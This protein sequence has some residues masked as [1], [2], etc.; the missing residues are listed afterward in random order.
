MVNDLQPPYPSVT[1]VAVHRNRCFQQLRE[2]LARPMVTEC[3]RAD[4]VRK[5]LELRPL[6][7]HQR[8]CLEE[9]DH[10]LKEIAPSSNYVHEGAI[11][12][13]VPLDVAD[14]SK[15][16][17]DQTKNLSTIVVLTHV[18]LRNQLKTSAA[19][20]IAVHDHG[21]GTLSVDVTGNVAIQ[22]FLLIVRTRHIFTVPS[23]PDGRVV[24]DTRSFQHIAR[25]IDSNGL[26]SHDVLNPARVPL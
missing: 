12:P 24:R 1:P 5:S 4:D 15:P 9:R 23:C 7:R 10:D 14:S 18:K 21:E 2:A 20:W 3:H 11:T 26:L 8:R 25:F 17:L 16:L 22:P 13:P 6:G 19:G